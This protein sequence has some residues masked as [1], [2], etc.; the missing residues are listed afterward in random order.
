MEN[1]PKTPSHRTPVSRR[2]NTP[3]KSNVIKADTKAAKGC[4]TERSSKIKG[5]DNI[6]LRS[7]VYNVLP[8]SEISPDVEG[9]KSDT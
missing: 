8:R 5:L 9:L 7:G 3:T 4:G 2:I 1:R 6:L